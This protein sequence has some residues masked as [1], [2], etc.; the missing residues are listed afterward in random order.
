[1]IGA[2]IG[3]RQQWGNARWSACLRGDKLAGKT[4][5]GTEIVNEAN[6][7]YFE[8][9]AGRIWMAGVSLGLGCKYAIDALNDGVN[10]GGFQSH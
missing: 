3:V 7:R 2:R 10:P 5:A 4:C 9:A 8:P 1:M 6:R